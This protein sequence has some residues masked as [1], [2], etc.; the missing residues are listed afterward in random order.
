LIAAQTVTRGG[1]LPRL[2]TAAQVLFRKVNG[3]LS[4]T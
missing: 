3:G 4:G 2:R 1:F